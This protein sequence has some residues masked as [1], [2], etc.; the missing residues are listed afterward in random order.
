[1]KKNDIVR[2]EITALTAEG[3]GVGRYDGMAV[4][5]PNTAVGDV[6]ECK[7]L[8]LK[9]SYAYGKIEKI[10]SA[11]SDRVDVDCPVYSRCGA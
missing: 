11:S 3:S 1:M 2:L 8:K 10:I 7:L 4:F 9:S 5:V 6:I